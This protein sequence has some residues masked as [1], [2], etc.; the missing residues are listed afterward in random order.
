[1]NYDQR[2]GI[3][4]YG[5]SEY[6]TPGLSSIQLHHYFVSDRSYILGMYFLFPTLR[7]NRTMSE[8]GK[9]KESLSQY[10]C[11]RKSLK[12]F[13]ENPFYERGLSRIARRRGN[14]ELSSTTFTRG[15]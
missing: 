3:S 15:I 4:T 2:R 13:A 10:A 8:Y 6:L 5:N 11:G 9:Y 12:R 1:M 14:R 7:D